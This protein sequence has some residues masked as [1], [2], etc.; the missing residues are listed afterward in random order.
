MLIQK[1]TS[2]EN[3]NEKT[4]SFLYPQDEAVLGGLVGHQMDQHSVT[5]ARVGPFYPATQI[6]L[7]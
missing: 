1:I 7:Y 3:N 6:V 2:E 4:H 5:S